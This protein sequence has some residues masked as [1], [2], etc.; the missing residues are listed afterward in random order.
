MKW[1]VSKIFLVVSLSCFVLAAF[2]FNPKNVELLSLGL[3]FM[4]AGALVA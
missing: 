4:V 1:N 3:A 2:G